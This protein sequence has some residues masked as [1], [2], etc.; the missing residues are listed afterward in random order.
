MYLTKLEGCILRY[1]KRIDELR[2]LL[3]E[4]ELNGYLIPSYDEFKNEY[5][6]SHLKRLGWLTGFDG[7]NGV[8]LVTE[9]KLIFFTDT[10]YTAQANR[11]LN[12]SYRILD[13]YNENSWHAVLESLSESF[14]LGYD[15]MIESIDSVKN[16]RKLISNRDIH[17]KSVERNLIDLLW[18]N[19]PKVLCKSILRLTKEE[20]GLSTSEKI[21]QLLKKM[22]PNAE[23]LL[24]NQLDA[25]CWLLNIRG[26]DIE[27]SPLIIA[28][29]IIKKDGECYLFTDSI[30]ETIENVE[31]LKLTKI[32]DFFIN[33][34]L[35][36]AFI[37]ASC[38]VSSWFLDIADNSLIT[39]KSS[40]EMMKACKNDI[41]I[42]NIKEAHFLD[43]LALCKFICWLEDNIDRATE[44][45]AAKELLKFRKAADSFIG[46]SFAT[47]SAFAENGAVIHY[48]PTQK[49]D[50][51]ITDESLY[52][53]D[54]GGQYKFGTTDVTR[55]FCFGAPSEQ[56]KRNYTLVLKGM[57]RLSQMKFPIGTNGAQLD[58]LARF[59]LW[60]HGL[61]YAHSTGHG[62]GY[63]LFV[64]EGPQRISKAGS[65]AFQP[66]MITSNEPGYYE[67]GEY[68]IRIENMML[69]KKSDVEGFLE[70]ETLTLV[71]IAQNLIE[72]SL[73]NNSE[74]EWLKNYNKKIFKTMLP[75]LDESEKNRLQRIC[76]C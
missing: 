74:R 43:G 66:G 21:E 27:Y 29:L 45:S 64:H 69:V 30:D 51:I 62:V 46:L 37:E 60:Q 19:K 4:Y 75:H 31:I 56:Q 67:E 34:V 33:L 61:D 8:L 26:G 9:D 13:I 65:V 40:V 32:K 38:D 7:S 76:D 47:I 53:L 70:F 59:D 18:L 44:I 55:T 50:K 35:S 42:A 17:F 36:G 41:E 63:F 28:Y 3:K 24:I 71:P 68:G 73:M 1:S 16:Y 52:L 2:E 39:K 15:P 58:S 14:V 57:I 20:A 23:Y 11:Q 25:I 48:K 5:T 10:R 72:F 49:T 22:E 12:E 6:P 54:S